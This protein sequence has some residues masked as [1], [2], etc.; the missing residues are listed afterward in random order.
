MQGVKTFL[1]VRDLSLG[2]FFLDTRWRRVGRYSNK[3]DFGRNREILPAR[4]RTTG[5]TANA[6][7]RASSCG[8]RCGAGYH[9]RKRL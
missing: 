3:V 1:L 4:K 6:K 2:G 8:F 7:S 9:L 5:V